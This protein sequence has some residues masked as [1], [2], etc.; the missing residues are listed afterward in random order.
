M[1]GPDGP[2]GDALVAAV[3]SGAVSEAAVDDKVPRASLRLAARV[4]ALGGTARAAPSPRAGPT[5]RSRPSC[6]RTAAASFVLARN[7]GSLLPLEAGSLRTRRRDRARTR[8]SR[9]RSAA[10]A[11]P[12]SRRYTVS[13]LDGL[14]AAL[15][16]RGHARA[17]RAHRTRGCRSP[18]SQRRRALPRRRRAPCS[19][20]E[21]REIGEFTWLGTLD[22][23]RRGDRGPHDAA[24]R[25]GGR[26]PRRLLR[27]GALP[28]HAATAS[29]PSTSELALREGADPGEALFAPPQHGVPVTLAEGEALDVVLRR[30]RRRGAMVTLRAQLPA[31]VRRRGRRARAGGRAG[32]RG[33]RRDRRRRHH[34]RGRER[35][36]RPRVARAARPP[37][38][39]RR[40]AST[41]RSRARSSSSTR[42]RRC[43]CR[44]WTRCPAVLL[45]WFPGQEAGNALADVLFGA[46]EPGGRLPT[47][48]PASEDG[49]AVGDARRRRPR[50]RRGPG[51]RLPRAD[52]AAA[53]VRPRARLHDVGVPGDGRRDAC[54]CATPARAAAARSSRSTRRARTARS[55]GRRAGSSASPS[56]EADA[57][58]EIVIDIPLS[59]R[60]FQHWDGGWQTEPGEFVLEAGRSRR[61]PAR[62]VHMELRQLEYF[63]AVARHRHFT[64]AAEAL[65]VTQ[66]ALSQQIRRLE[67]ELGL[68]L[69]RRTSKGV[70]LTAAG[71]DLLV[72]AEAVLAEV[73]RREADMDRHTGRHARGRAGRGDGGRRAA[74]A[75]GARGLPRR[76]PGHPDRAAAGLGGGGRR[77]GRG[78]DGRRRRAG[79]DRG[80]A[81]ASTVHPLADEPLRVAVARRRR[82]RRARRSTLGRAARAPVHPRRAGHRAA[83]DGD[84]GGAGGRVQPAAAVRGRRP[85]DGALPGPGGARDQPRAGELARAAGAGRRRGGPSRSAAPPAAAAHAGRGRPHRPAGC[86]TSA[87]SSSSS[88]RLRGREPTSV[89]IGAPLWKSMNVGI[90]STPYCAATRL[91]VVDV[92]LDDPEVVAARRRSRRGSGSSR[93]TAGTTRR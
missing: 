59:P 91:V 65:Y 25:A 93:G 38:R 28:A 40:G 7:H 75:R 35:G 14:R 27:A 86:C 52:R 24:R 92:E 16:G 72:H 2:W 22:P 1:P 6:A 62:V 17:R 33:R 44:G 15:R 70:E 34:A 54:G 19:R 29:R 45:C 48:W 5:R 67:A 10:A 8:P 3:R 56:I 42:A 31:A 58:E 90:E 82:A 32:A 87:C 60:A 23:A 63:A 49:P 61:G 43:C 37:G 4:G 78:G 69:L 89:W 30:E 73:A 64:R 76:P 26:A 85:A 84:G 13:P 74:A 55:S 46:A 18:T 79:A 20:A 21:H 53:A 81:R 66:P 47:T 80:A 50:L 88:R 41:T 57:G 71:A 68:T 9:A 39:A 36:L 83:R 12:S 51:D 77:A 11:R